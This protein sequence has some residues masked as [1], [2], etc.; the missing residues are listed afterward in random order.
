VLKLNEVILVHNP[1]HALENEHGIF[2][3]ISPIGDVLRLT[4]TPGLPQDLPYHIAFRPEKKRR[5]LRWEIRKI[6]DLPCCQA[7]PETP[8]P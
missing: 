7:F 5:D 3:V 8:Q 4:C 1:S 2:E 6:A